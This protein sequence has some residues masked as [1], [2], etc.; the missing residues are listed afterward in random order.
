MKSGFISV[1]GRTN[2]G[3]STLVNS[4][5]GEKIAIISNKPQTTRYRIMGIRTTK[6]S[7]I[8]FTDTPGIHNPKTRLGDFMINE[9]KESLND[10]DAALLVVEPVSNVGKS[11]EKI[12]ETLKNLNIPTILVINKIDTIKKEDLFPIIEKYSKAY[13]FE[14]IIPVS[15][16][17]KDGMEI[18][19]KEIDKYLVEGPMFFPEDM[20]TDSPIKQRI[21]EIVREKLLWALDKEIPHGIAIEVSTLKED[22]KKVNLDVVIYCEKQSH[23]GIIIGKG[24]E[25]LKNV[26]IK[27]RYDIENLLGKKVFLNLWVKVKEGWRDSTMLLKNFGFSELQ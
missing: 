6:D 4:L 2:A 18:L 9:A 5:I 15:A 26:G 21:S 24:G 11:E 16:K 7:Q 13:D 8:V 20:V 22:D 12:I 25:Q 10:T 1:V 3:K 19:L 14:S 17:T 27:S 23:K